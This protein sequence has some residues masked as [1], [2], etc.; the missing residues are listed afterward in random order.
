MGG[1]QATENFLYGERKIDRPDSL[2]QK[3]SEN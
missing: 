1:D 3:E 2:D